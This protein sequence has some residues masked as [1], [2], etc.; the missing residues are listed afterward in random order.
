MKSIYV[1]TVVLVQR[2]F[3]RDRRRA[4]RQSGHTFL[5]SSPRLPQFSA[6][7]NTMMS[8]GQANPSTS[9]EFLPPDLPLPFIADGL[10]CLLR[11]TMKD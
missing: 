1:R 9:L 8:F 7:Q 2:E 6:N 5:V 3:D 4:N 10:R 11:M